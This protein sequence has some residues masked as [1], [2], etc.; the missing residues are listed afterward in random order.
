[1]DKVEVRDKSLEWEQLEMHGPS[2]AACLHE[3]GPSRLPQR[4]E[5]IE[6]RLSGKSIKII[7]IRGLT[8]E[9]AFLLIV[10][11]HDAID[12]LANL[13]NQGV[14]ELGSEEFQVLRI[15]AGFPAMGHELTL[16]YTPLE[17][18]V[19][20]WVSHTK[21]CYTGQEVI[22]RQI[23][24]DKVTKNLVQL[25]VDQS[26][27]PKAKVMVAGKNVGAITSAACS[28]RSGPI[29]LA[30]IKRPHHS[31]GTAVQIEIGNGR[32]ATGEVAILPAKLQST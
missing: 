16:D 8:S 13:H 21:G 29:A 19:A 1:M 3:M 26:V 31:P 12:L 15:E 28:P 30:V 32:Y 23:S 27:Q 14:A 2:A 11:P 9:V 7:G 22:A 20:H 25:T 17:V 5:V 10:S 24:Y 6:T 4:N 18:G